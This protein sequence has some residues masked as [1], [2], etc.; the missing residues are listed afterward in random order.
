MEITYQV[1]ELDKVAKQLLKQ[2]KSKTVLFY[3]EMGTGKTT[4]IKALVKA[5]GSD[6][7]VSSPTFSIVNEYV[8]ETSPIYH[9]DFYRIEDENEALNFGVEEYL[10]SDGWILIEWPEKVPNILPKNAEMVTLKLNNNASRTLKLSQKLN[11]T[12]EKPM[13]QE[14][15]T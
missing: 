4:L 6:D 7:N 12:E 15:L 11:L 10:Y 3:G 8:T 5:L 13:E 1:N 9:F 2:F 14:N